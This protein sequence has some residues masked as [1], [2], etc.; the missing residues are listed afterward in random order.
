MPLETE[1]V[2]S[3]APPAPPAYAKSNQ[4]AKVNLPAATPK[5]SVQATQNTAVASVKQAPAPK[6]DQRANPPDPEA[7]RIQ[8]EFARL[9]DDSGARNAFYNEL[10]DTVKRVRADAGDENPAAE[11][12]VSF[13]PPAPSSRK[14]FIEPPNPPRLPEIIQPLPELNR[15][16]ESPPAKPPAPQSFL[17]PLGDP[18]DRVAYERVVYWAT[19]NGAP[20]ALALGVAWME[21]HLNPNA[22][23]GSSGEVGIFQIMPERCRL[24]GQPPERL[25]EPEFNAWMGTLLL[26]RYYQE[27]GSVARAAAKYVAG[28][29]VFNKEYSRDMWAYINWYATTVDTYASYFSRY[30]S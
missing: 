19:S 1:F 7:Q 14:D 2:P 25:G 5:R 15:P 26:A 4:S 20:V 10:L 23:R 29:K 22:A 18:I 9:R 28:P 12:L 27:E 8:D 6:P 24:E 11:K 13:Q 21:S 17:G 16:Q 3:H 30:Q